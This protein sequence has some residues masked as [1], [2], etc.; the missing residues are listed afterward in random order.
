MPRS[1]QHAED[2]SRLPE[3]FRRIGYDADTMRYTFTD[4]Q[5]KL[6]RSAPG[7]E[8]GTLTPV[9]F[10][11][12]T[13]RPGAFSDG[14]NSKIRQTS[15]K[16]TFSDFLPP[17]AMASA[18]SSLDQNL[19]KPPPNAYFNGAVRTALPKRLGVMQSL[20]RSITS[21]YTKGSAKN[22]SP[23]PPEDGKNAT[24]SIDPSVEKSKSSKPKA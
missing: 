10:S 18:S 24:G 7:E 17:T 9:A 21:A 3:G 12:S 6:Y 22:A 2:S 5:G 8:Y 16:L 1:S 14:N 20:R 11:A 19:P 13:D 15:R 4:K 23:R